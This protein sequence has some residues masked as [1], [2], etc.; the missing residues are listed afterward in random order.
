MAPI[1]KLLIANRGEIARRVIRSARDLGIRTVA[2]FSE[3]DQ[4]APHVGEADEAVR[5]G[6][7]PASESYL[8]LARVMDAVRRTGADALHPGYGFL[9]ENGD[10]ARACTEAGVTFVGPPEAAVRLMGDKVQ[11]KRRMI[12]AGVPTA[13]GYTGEAQDEAT[14]RAEA[15]RVGLPL[16]VK[17]VAGGGG[18][19]MRVV[20][21]LGELG[22]AVASA[23]SEAEHAFGR[24]DV[25]LER[26]V[27]GA[28]HV[29]IQ[30]FADSHGHVIHLGERECSVQRRHQKIIEEAPSPAVDEALRARMGEAA[31]AAARAI[32][33]EGAGTVEFLLTGEGQFYFLEMNTRLQVEHPVTEM[34]TGL[35]LV[36]LQLRVAEGEPLPIT[37][38]EV[39]LTGH[40]IEAR[41][42]AEDPYAGFAPQLGRIAAW[43]PRRGKGLRVDD[44]VASGS[45]IS[46]YYDSMVAKLIAYG[47]TRE[48]ARRRLTAAVRDGV[49]LG[50]GSNRTF[51]LALLD[52]PRFASAQVTTDT[53]DRWLAEEPPARPSPSALGWAVAAVLHSGLAARYP[54]GHTQPWPWRSAGE[55]AW[56]VVLREHED[57]RTLRVAHHGEGRFAVKG[58]AADD[59]AS[60]GVVELRVIAPD[61]AQ[62]V[63]EHEGVLR[64]LAWACL[65]D[66]VALD[67]QGRAF[68]FHEPPPRTSTDEADGGDGAVKAPIG[69]RVLSRL[70]AE[71]DTV[72]PGQTLLVI[73]AM[74][75]E[76]RVPAPIAG[77]VERLS[78][79]EGDQVAAG[80]V[81]AQL[82]AEPK[83]EGS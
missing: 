77:R 26:L 20:R 36:E 63:V 53:I 50:P 27:E 60:D 11:A 28:R 31:V 33:Y 45:V 54:E 62:I 16:L 32:A 23:R 48:Q 59:A 24:G 56:P 79:A 7:G 74:K 37:Q 69:G 1:R 75:M 57:T 9:S 64:R 51:L 38:D 80:Q 34:V 40:A 61:D 3:A 72:E 10:L 73:E 44:G 19:G 55:P 30:V 8:D 18:R 25:F 21:S 71:G 2:V 6:P 52:D 68:S 43:R 46:P 4:G 83:E 42:Y 15:E 22:S 5:L 66:G 13:P 81:V 14:L 39:T 47:D 65:D 29:E 17:A 58:A 76:H 41:I 70:V 67:E 82:A 12:E 49:L 35:D 78:V